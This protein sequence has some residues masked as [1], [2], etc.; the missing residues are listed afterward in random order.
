MT[1]AEKPPDSGGFHEVERALSVLQGRDP[2]AMQAEREA[3]EAKARRTAQLEGVAGRERRRRQMMMVVYAAGAGAALAVCGVLWGMHARAEKADASL[4]PAIAPF[5]EEGFARVPSGFFS[6]G[7]RVD[8]DVPEG[9]CVLA[10]ASPGSGPIHLDRPGGSDSA[11][12]SVLRCGCAPEHVSARVDVAPGAVS[13]VA[14]L[15]VDARTVGGRFGVAFLEPRPALLAPGGEACASEHLE[16]YVADAR[17]PK[18]PP[19]E[20]WRATPEGKALTARGFAAIARVPAD[21]PLAVLEPATDKCFVATGGGATVAL[22]VGGGV[23]VSAPNVA[24]CAA[25]VG[26]VLVE[27]TGTGTIDVASAPVRRTGGLLGLR[28]ALASA[29]IDA[30]VW[31]PATDHAALAA[32]AL[33]ASLIP[34]VTPAPDGSIL[35]SASAD[36]RVVSLSAG[37]DKTFEPDS[38]SDAFFLCAPPISAGTR[39]N[40]CVQTAPQAWHPPPPDVAAGA[41]YG[42]LPVWL[43]AWSKSRDPEVIKLE[44]GLVGLARRL[45]A[46]G[47][48]P[49]IIEG[50]TEEDAGASVVGRSGEDA[51]VAVGVWPAPPWVDP[52]GDPAWSIDGEPRVVPLVG[53]QRVRF[54]AHA[55]TTAPLAARRTVVFRHAASR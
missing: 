50:V 24:W 25:K 26:V 52:Y 18:S 13:A 37:G 21:R 48:E 38:A 44:L 45:N 33:R 46:L 31:A 16:A 29:A 54:F 1:D 7:Q 14:L 20:S 32:E 40:L 35:K 47:Y 51:I 41:A 36:A 9:T 15:R 39:Q 53:G 17:Y 19:S 4:A 8:L 43:A 11:S 5:L 10:V 22:R 42:P 2:R 49:T 12:G 3:R 6:T 30:A 27:R 34:D 23:V 28:D 55:R